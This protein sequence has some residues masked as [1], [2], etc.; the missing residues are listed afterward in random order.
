MQQINNISNIEN[1]YCRIKLD[2][3]DGDLLKIKLVWENSY[4]NLDFCAFFLSN[5]GSVGGIFTREYCGS[6]NVEGALQTYPYMK[7]IGEEIAEEDIDFCAE[8]IWI[9]RMSEMKR[10]CFVAIDYDAAISEEDAKFA[11]DKAKLIIS[12]DKETIFVTDLNSSSRGCIY[13]I[14]SI[15]NEKDG[16][17][18][19]NHYD[20]LIMDLKTAFERIPGFS[21]LVR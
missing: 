4:I 11:D 5:D 16:L 13:S 14:C 17:Y 9:R 2:Y 18:I 3:K 7:L 19:S 1:P 8:E 12:N 21:K 6:E 20:N 15:L 10:I